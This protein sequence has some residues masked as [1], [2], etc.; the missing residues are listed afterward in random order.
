MCIFA[1]IEFDK[2]FTFEKVILLQKIV[3]NIS[4]LS[5]VLTWEVKEN[6]ISQDSKLLAPVAYFAEL[7]YR[8]SRKSNVRLTL[9][10]C[11]DQPGRNQIN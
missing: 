10:F 3:G 1:R 8:Q 4:P 6:Y 11:L 5:Y 2:S 7:V 9:D